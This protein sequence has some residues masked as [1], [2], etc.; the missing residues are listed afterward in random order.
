MLVYQRVG[1]HDVVSDGP[2]SSGG[3][4]PIFTPSKTH[5][6]LRRGG[7]VF[8]EILLLNRYTFIFFPSKLPNYLPFTLVCRMKDSSQKKPVR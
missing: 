7:L 8:F 1:F 5:A 4:F 6:L 2:E 3:P